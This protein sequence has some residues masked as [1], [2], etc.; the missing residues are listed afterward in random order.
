MTFTSAPVAAAPPLR[1]NRSF[2]LLW[3][4]EGV[5]VLGNATTSILLPLLAV[6]GFGAGAGWMGA[7]TAAAWL[8]WVVVGLPA[9]AWIDRMDARRVMIGSDIFAALTLSSVPLAWLLDRLTLP[10]LIGAALANGICTVFFRTAYVKLIAEVVDTAHLEQAN[11]R[12]IGTESAMQVVGPGL[13]GVMAQLFSAAGGIVVDA[14]SFIVSAIC[15]MRI[16]TP[17]ARPEPVVGR[18]PLRT[19]IREGIGYVAHDRYLRALTVIGAVSN[20]GLTGYATLLVL[21]MVDDLNLQPSL[22]G[23]VMMLGSIG[24][25][26]GA[27]VARPLSRRW[28]SGRASTILLVLGSPAALLVP[29]ASPGWGASWLVAGL[30]LV[31]MFVVAGNVIRGAWR[32]L[33]VPAHLMGRV[34]TSIQVVNFGAMPAAGILAGVLGT[35]LG[36]RETIAL[37]TF[38]HMAACLGILLTPL[39]SLRVLPPGAHG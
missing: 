35:A 1:L 16:R 11:A 29:L 8:P 4:G 39:R 25:L 34:V 24:G 32:Q 3:F 7:L 18:E 17:Q 23:T 2:N 9:G 38:I 30:F 12:L 37:M 33:Y 6:T 20:F 28:G 14:L 26:L 22:V 10:H 27:V 31:G 19:Q 5:S 15:L 36:I 13:G 21:F